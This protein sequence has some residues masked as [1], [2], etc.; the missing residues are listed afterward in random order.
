MCG[1]IYE[2]ELVMFKHYRVFKDGTPVNGVVRA[3]NEKDA[4]DQVY[5][6]LG[7]ASR[8]SGMSR[9]SLVAKEVYYGGTQ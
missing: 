2:E 6:K 9:N 5:M 1:G 3:V 7:S 8:F 4:I